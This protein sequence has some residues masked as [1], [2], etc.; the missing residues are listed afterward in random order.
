MIHASHSPT[1]TWLV[2]S[3]NV[4][5]PGQNHHLP[6][7]A[8]TGF[9]DSLMLMSSCIQ[10]AAAAAA[11]ATGH[12]GEDCRICQ[13]GEYRCV[14]GSYCN[15]KQ[16]RYRQ[17]TSA[18]T[19]TYRSDRSHVVASPPFPPVGLQPRRVRLRAP[20]RVRPLPQEPPR[21]TDPWSHW[22]I[23]VWWLRSWL[24]WQGLLGML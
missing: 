16:C 5:C 6:L 4:S 17:K 12:G 23:R 2:L 13:T 21:L 8:L 9:S 24:W 3:L 7:G 22:C 10:S 1:I 15:S 11:A 19:S 20:P 14:S 18:N